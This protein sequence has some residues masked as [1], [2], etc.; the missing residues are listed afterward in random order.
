M[1]DR[2]ALT[3]EGEIVRKWEKIGSWESDVEK[4]KEGAPIN[5]RVAEIRKPREEPVGEKEPR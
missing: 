2:S 4:N 5:V 1:W 3:R